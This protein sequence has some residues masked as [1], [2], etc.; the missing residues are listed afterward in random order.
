MHTMAMCQN[1]TVKNMRRY[2]GGKNNVGKAVSI[3]IGKR[4]E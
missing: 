4:A 2:I 3:A 1:S